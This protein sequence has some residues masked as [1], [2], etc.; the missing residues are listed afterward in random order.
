MTQQKQDETEAE[1]PLFIFHRGNEELRA[2]SQ[3]VAGEPR[4][5]LYTYNHQE[6]VRKAVA[7]RMDELPAVMD[8]L[9]QM[10]E[11]HGTENKKR[12]PKIPAIP[13]M[14]KPPGSEHLV[15]PWEDLPDK[16]SQPPTPTNDNPNREIAIPAD[17][18]A[19]DILAKL[20]D[21][22]VDVKSVK[23]NLWVGELQGKLLQDEQDTI[24]DHEY[25][26]RQLLRAEKDAENLRRPG[27]KMKRTEVGARENPDLIDYQDWLQC[28]YPKCKKEYRGNLHPVKVIINSGGILTIVD[29]TGTKLD[30]HDEP[31]DRG[32]SIEI[33]FDGE[34]GHASSL[35]FHFHKGAT[36][37][38]R[39]VLG[40]HVG[41]EE[42]WDSSDTIWRD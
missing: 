31:D 20:R 28:P 42:L 24:R 14:I 13:P 18:T 4:V 5:R 15:P 17:M 41:P 19:A 6:G 29:H 9:R 2:E 22:G 33:F 37:F 1:K 25:E 32:V 21:L 8:V 36:R 3:F 35:K 30:T 11:Q 34:C 12:P 26:I 39:Y 38:A 40:K 10:E 7:I 16:P 27:W 23:G